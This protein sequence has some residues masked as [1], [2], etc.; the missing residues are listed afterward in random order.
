MTEKDKMEQL[1]EKLVLDN[2]PAPILTTPM[3]QQAGERLS[4]AVAV[5]G[6]EAVVRKLV[7]D[8]SA[9]T[10]DDLE[11]EEEEQPKPDPFIKAVEK[12]ARSESPGIKNA[13]TESE[14][15][16]R[17]WFDGESYCSE[18][19]CALRKLC[20][21]AYHLAV[22]SIDD[23]IDASEELEGIEA[24]VAQVNEILKS[25]KKQEVK[26]SV[27]GAHAEQRTLQKK[28]RR[29]KGGKRAPGT[30]RKKMPYINQGRPV[31]IFANS[32]WKSLGSPPS[33]PDNWRYKTMGSLE[34]RQFAQ[35][36]FVDEYGEGL[37]VTRRSG[38]HQFIYNGM[39]VARLWV[40]SANGGWLDM[41]P[42]LAEEVSDNLFV[43]IKSVPKKNS[44]H[45][46]VI[47]TKR[48]YVN[49]SEVADRIAE[50]IK[51]I[52]DKMEVR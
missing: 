3:M 12:I 13:I 52:L 15:F 10:V 5:P 42:T 17:F 48:V 16:A 38:Y 6:A 39:H 26:G 22:G 14:C 47:Y 29:H 51:N 35:Q 25:E 8:V 34:W 40:N 24:E 30:P 36:W 37:M 44:K 1:G 45:L 19:E 41:N 46:F 28:R 2:D 9:V 27:V 21:G 11:D 23:D 33:L 7:E 18:A 32:L 31:D 50:C 43:K 4:D 49:T 20:E